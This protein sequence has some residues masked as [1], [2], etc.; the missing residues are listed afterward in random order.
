MRL[1]PSS[2]FYPKKSSKTLKDSKSAPRLG[3]ESEKSTPLDHPSSSLSIST[4]AAASSPSSSGS[5]TNTNPNNIVLWNDSHQLKFK[6]CKTNKSC[7]V[8][9]E[10][11]WAVVE[12]AV[13]CEECNLIA[14]K[15]L[16]SSN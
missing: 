5:N 8:C 6:V 14:H 10:K 13:V 1:R 9:Y 3:S 16:C 7:S 12:Q 2:F 11:I 4:N 15:V